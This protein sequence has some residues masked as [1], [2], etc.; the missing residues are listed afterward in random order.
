MT[1]FT[2][3]GFDRQKE[4]NHPDSDDL[5]TTGEKAVGFLLVILT[6]ELIGGLIWLI[7]T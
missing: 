2:N 7:M 4:Y 5:M 6:I 1:K 3:K